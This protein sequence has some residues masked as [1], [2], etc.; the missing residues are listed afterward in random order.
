MTAVDERPDTA[1]ART[2][3]DGARAA[4]TA[5]AVVA[6]G[7]LVPVLGGEDAGTAGL[8]LA[9]AAAVAVVGYLALTASATLLFTGVF[10]LQVFSGNWVYL[11][12]PLGLDRVLLV[13]AACALG[14][15]QLAGRP[16]GTRIRLEPTHVLLAL[17]VVWAVLSAMAAGTLLTLP[18]LFA[19]LDR[20]GLVPF[21]A[22][23]L[24]PRLYG[25]AQQRRVLLVALTATG[26]YLAGTALAQGIGADAL[27][28]PRYVLDE[29]LG[30]HAER[31][32]GPFLE[33][34]AMGCALIVCA[35]AA[36]VAAHTWAS[37]LARR[38]AAAVCAAALLATLF[39]LTRAIWLATVLAVLLVACATPRWRR[40]IIPA[41]VAGA[42]GLVVLLTV[43][44]GLAGQVSDRA[45]SQR[46]LWDRYNSNAAALE[47]V[48]EL[49]LTGVG[50]QRFPE[51]SDD[52][53]VQASTYPV[54]GV[55]IEVH[56]VFLSHAA[57]LGLP[58]AGLY[59]LCWV[60]AVVPPLL[61]RGGPDHPAWRRALLAVAVTWLVVASFGP[62]SYA[63]ANTA[64]WLFAGVA[65]VTS[66]DG[67]DRTTPS[68]AT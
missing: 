35:A 9:G 31:A 20:L 18:G 34:V 27:V 21:L 13:A 15:D 26:A 10:V 49:P 63:F 1:P 55:G 54:T 60:Y 58:G 46:P 7:A 44:P 3:R 24:A 37:R 51:V 59:L 2:W 12:I 66:R 32:R 39:T 43:V 33:A 28:F 65:A 62:L 53:T 42:V 5:S 45:G 47:I 68:V 14:R 41:G 30:I 40:W 50:W 4:G 52:W 36:A 16:S 22:F 23:V 25:T 48:S 38:L 29:S 57:E 56:N 6:A 61:R 67:G 64:L 19:L 8:L 17:L 11:G